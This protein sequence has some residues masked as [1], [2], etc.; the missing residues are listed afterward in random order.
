M[1]CTPL[2]IIFC[3]LEKNDSSVGR[4]RFHFHAGEQVCFELLYIAEINQYKLYQRVIINVIVILCIW[5]ATHA[6]METNNSLLPT[7]LRVY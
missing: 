1:C 7:C 5:R 3:F 6:L 2:H 4:N